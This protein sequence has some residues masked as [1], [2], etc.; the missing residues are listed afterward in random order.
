EDDVGVLAQRRAQRIGEARRIGT[1]L[2]LVH[3]AALVAMQ[4]LDRVLD[5]E[6]VLRTVAV[7]LVDQRGKRRRLARARGAGDENEAARLLREHVQRVRN[8]ELLERFELR[9]NQTE[10]GADR[11]ALE[12]DVDAEA[13]EPRNRIREVELT[14]ELEMLLLLAGQN[15]VQQLLRL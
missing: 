4:E 15:A 7:D 14:V 3:D 9:W 1:D 8:A 5:R 13:R 11:F 2:A 6:D 10:R 12:V